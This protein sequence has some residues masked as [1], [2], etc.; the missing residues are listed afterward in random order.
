MGIDRPIDIT[1]EQRKVILALLE[2]HLPNTTAWV[3]GS[4]ANWSARPQS[5]LDMVVFAKPGQNQQ[6]SRLKEAFQESDIPFRVDLFIWDNVPEN[7]RKQIAGDHVALVQKKKRNTRNNWRTVRLR[8]V[9][10]L[11]LSSVDK[12]I[13]HEET[14]VR[15]CNYMDVYNNNFIRSNMSFMKAT[16]TDREISNCSLKVGDVVLTKDS[17]KYDDIGIPALVRD[18]I[19]NLVC[20]YH[21]AILRPNRDHLDGNYLLY[22]LGFGEAQR[23]FHAYAN[24][25]TRFGL[26][27]GDIGRIEIALPSIAEQRAIAHILGTLDDKIELNQRMNETLEAMAQAL[28]KSWFVDFDPVRAKMEGRDTGLPEPIAYLFPNRMVDSE[29]GEIPYGWPVVPLPDL[30]SINPSRRL[31]KGQTAPYLEMANMP[32][33]GHVPDLVTNRPFGS[34][35]RFMNGDT[36]IARITP[37]LENGK[38]AYVDFLPDGVIGWGSTEYIVMR[39]KP[40]LPNEF[41]YCLAR[42]ARF[43]EFAIQN[44]TGT[45]GRQRLPAKALTQFPQVV[46]TK[47]V[48]ESFRNLIQPLIAQAGAAA[49]ES[50]AMSALRD[51]L[52]PRLISGE[53]R[54]DD[55]NTVETTA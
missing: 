49:G 42:S 17:E 21:L 9:V 45:S 51:T 30:I 1:A 55:W 16:A 44:M 35:M 23:Q 14:P 32:T 37:C 46:P 34:G 13:K 41:A 19:P 33:K 39:P 47:R 6:V 24:G 29:I 38:T 28:F 22:A 8:D 27:K 40:P 43:R 25:V 15:L 2:R 50:R 53:L 26:R 54:V 5:D 3:Y 48:A 36:L 20:G 11:R 52:L 10:D 31:Q 12:K 18:T 4:R 7:F